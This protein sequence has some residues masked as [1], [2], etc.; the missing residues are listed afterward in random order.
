MNKKILV[1]DD[2]KI[3]RDMNSRFVE[4]FGYTPIKAETSQLAYELVHSQSPDLVWTDH[5]MPGMTGSELIDKLRQE[6]N[7][8]SFLVT[9]GRPE[10]ERISLEAGANA[11]LAKPYLLPVVKALIDRL[12][13]E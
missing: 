12:L 7:D 2:D 10:N 9:S 1:V 11:Y 3:V 5:D 6:G 4:I 13:G 8:V